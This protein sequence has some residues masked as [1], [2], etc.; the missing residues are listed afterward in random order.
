LSR[1]DLD[2]FRFGTAIAGGMVADSWERSERLPRDRPSVG[3]TR[4]MNTRTLGQGLEVSEQGLGCMGMSA[5]YGA[6]DEEESV[7]TIH[8]ALELGI[9]F[10]DTAD[11]YGLGENERL[12]GRALAGRR[13]DVVLATRF[14]NVVD[15]DGSRRIDGRPEYV[16]EGSD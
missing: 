9:V 2:V 3:Q 5:W 16:H 6:T 4:G 13:D 11:I 15:D 7:A 12:V 14:G 1:R 8:R 10:V